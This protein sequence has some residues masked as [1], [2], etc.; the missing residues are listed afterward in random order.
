M[1]QYS[2]NQ[3]NPFSTG[4][5]G[6]NFET[7]VQAAFTTLMLSGH[8]AP[9]IPNFPIIKIKLQ[10][11]YLG[12]NT[13]D[14]IVFSREKDTGREAK[15]FAQ[16]KHEISFT[17]SSGTFAEVIDVAWKDF[18]H[19][20]VA[21]REVLSHITIKVAYMF[22]SYISSEFLIDLTCSAVEWVKPKCKRRV[23][24]RCNLTLLF[25]LN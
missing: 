22:D 17:E 25:K 13:D 6:V 18:N 24:S 20:D 15:L 21:M 5:G 23:N 12:Y 7:R 3:S 16:I 8:V 4:G 2:K 11:R 10:G 9:C 1:T 19:S 14:F